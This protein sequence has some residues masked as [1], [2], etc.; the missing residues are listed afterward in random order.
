MDAA[1]KL[2]AGFA[3]N[4]GDFVIVLQQG[5]DERL[6]DEERSTDHEDFHF[7]PAV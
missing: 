4:N 7:S 3:M 2:V 5:R 6:T 1:T